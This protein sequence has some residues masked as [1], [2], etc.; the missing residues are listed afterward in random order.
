MYRPQVVLEYAVVQQPIPV[1]S[2]LQVT[3][4]R[5]LRMSV[6][7]GDVDETELNVTISTG[8]VHYFRRLGLPLGESLLVGSYLVGMEM[9]MMIGKIGRGTP[10]VLGMGLGDPQVELL[11][12]AE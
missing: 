5:L 7:K 2:Q 9:M 12:G 6:V 3:L 10:C 11:E 4:V 1:G 8:V